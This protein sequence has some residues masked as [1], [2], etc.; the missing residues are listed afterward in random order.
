MSLETEKKEIED[1]YKKQL[2][3]IP[4]RYHNF[5]KGVCPF[6]DQCFYVH[7]N[8]DGTLAPVLPKPPKAHRHPRDPF[9]TAFWD[10]WEFDNSGDSSG[11]EFEF[12]ETDL[13]LDSI[14]RNFRESLILMMSDDD[15]FILVV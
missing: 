9:P 2:K 11:G 5:G 3:K 14:Y 7:L 10:F 12:S 6:Y 8:E 13:D 4:C 1:N 15:D